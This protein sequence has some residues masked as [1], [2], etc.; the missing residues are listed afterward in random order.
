MMRKNMARAYS[1]VMTILL[2]GSAATFSQGPLNLGTVGKDSRVS[3]VLSSQDGWGM[4]IDTPSTPP[5]LQPKP[6]QVEVDYGKDAVTEISAGY[7]SVKLAGNVA[8]AEADVKESAV[9]FH[10]SDT[11]TIDD[12]ILKVHR[13]LNVLGSAEGGFSSSVM[14]VT[15]PGNQWGGIKFFAPG[16]IYGDPSHDGARAPG[17]LMNEAMKRFA[18]REDFLEAPLL[19]MS[20]QNGDS[21]SVLDPTPQGD[22]TTEETRAGTNTTLVSENF[23]FGALGANEELGQ[24]VQFGFWM[25]GTISDISGPRMTNGEYTGQTSEQA[26]T[27]SWRRRYSPIRDGFSQNY[28]VQF[29]FGENEDFL[30]M[31]RNSWRWAWSV[32]RP[33]V[34]YRDLALIQKTLIDFLETRV[35]SIDGRTGIPYLLDSR[36][37]EYMSRADARRAAMGFCAKNI[38]AADQLLQEADRDSSPRGQRMRASGEAIID[39]FIRLIPMSP[40][41]G[42]GFN[43][44]TGKI[45]TAIWSVNQQF[46]RTV[47][48]EQ[49]TLLKAY[50]REK[51]LGR[52]HPDWLRWSKSFTDWLLTQQRADGSFPRAWY[53]G[54]GVVYN[55]S[56][57]A[58]Y[59]GPPLLT[60]FAKQ[61]GEKK[62]LDAAIRAG[63]YLW[64][65]NGQEGHYEGGAVDASSPELTTDKESGML[66]LEAFLSL[67]DATKDP[68]WLKRAEAAGDYTESWILIWNIPMPVDANDEEIQWKK[69]ITTVGLQGI[70]AKG[71]GGHDE[72]LDWGT[73]LYA[74]LYNNTKDPHYLDVAQILLQNTKGMLA[75]PGRTFGMLGPGWQ[76]EHWLMSA[77]RGYGQ[78]GKWLPWLATNHLHSIMT[79]EEYDPALYTELA[80][81]PIRRGDH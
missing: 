11:W 3:F 5:L 25:P 32:L 12:G 80:T 41:A 9:A 24:G 17:G 79:L 55:P 15:S 63:E 42:D 40:P 31:E 7:T 8:K 74:E 54:N 14:F 49:L 1:F 72:Y 61:T 35:V 56:G 51:S 38:E 57:S 22:T 65:H 77:N 26:A 68:K 66:S 50:Q 52:D 81:K 4:E 6:A 75:L 13:L 30:A 37:G 28:N 53:L 29:R 45:E 16:V 33:A 27:P 62:Y 43:L 47:A 64:Q 73:P 78:A 69:G 71:A 36:T 39:T 46:L 23:K 2:V 20:F 58:T 67:Y 70:T 21:I 44:F 10:I 19:A 59:M 60:A 18:F 34:D 76:Q 48:E